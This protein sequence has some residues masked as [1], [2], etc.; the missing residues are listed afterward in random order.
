VGQQ[1]GLGDF[2][3]VEPDRIVDEVGVQPLKDIKVTLKVDFWFYRVRHLRLYLFGEL[4]SVIA[5]AIC[6]QFV[7]LFHTVRLH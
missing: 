3:Q 2:A 5:N 7:N 6:D 4:S 1:R